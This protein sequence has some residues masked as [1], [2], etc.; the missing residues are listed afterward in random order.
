MATCKLCKNKIEKSGICP[1]CGTEYLNT[2]VIFIYGQSYRES[3]QASVCVTDKYLTVKKFSSFEGFLN[4]LSARLFGALGLLIVG[5]LL[6]LRKKHYAYYDLRDVQKVIY[7]YLTDKLKKEVALKF[8]N[9]D[10]SDFVLR[11]DTLSAKKNCRA[12]AETLASLGVYV[13]DGSASTHQVHCE[14]PFV[15]AQTFYTRICPSAATFVQMGKKQFVAQP[16]SNNAFVNQQ[17]NS[18]YQQVT[19]T[20]VMATPNQNQA[21][22]IPNIAYAP[23]PV[24]Q[25]VKVCHNCGAEVKPTAKFCTKCGSP[26]N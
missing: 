22:Q 12:F 16:I 3:S 9:K 10:G 1:Y 19:P 5:G 15:N 25:T 2:S 14:R 20:P 18:Y 4:V 6:S 24:V 23:N 26:L 8:V 21:Y 7:P 17:Q 11:I 13:E